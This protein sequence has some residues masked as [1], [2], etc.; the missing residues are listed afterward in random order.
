MDVRISLPEIKVIANEL[1][2]GT[3]ATITPSVH[4]LKKK[5][6]LF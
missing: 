1:V 3:R 5:S 6:Q 4:E 2:S